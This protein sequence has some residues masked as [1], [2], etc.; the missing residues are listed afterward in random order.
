MWG[1][2][3]AVLRAIWGHLGSALLL[4]AVLA[5]LGRPWKAE[6]GAK[7]GPRGAKMGEM[8]AQMAASCD[9]EVPR[10]TQERLVGAMLGAS[11][12]IWGAFG[13]HLCEKAGKRKTNL[14]KL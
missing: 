4:E 5:N 13:G 8:G 12:P 7:M 2:L 3:G 9:Q 6:D 1:G 14:Q 10:S 11:S